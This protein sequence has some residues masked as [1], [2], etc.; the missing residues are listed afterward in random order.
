MNLEGQEQASMVGGRS[1]RW[2]PGRRAAVAVLLWPL[3]IALIGLG[4]LLSFIDQLPDPVATHWGPGDVPDGF[5]ARSSLPWFILL[6]LVTGWLLGGLILT[7]AWREAMHRRVTVGF[8][9]GMTTFVT[10]VMVGTSWVQRGLTDA[11]DTGGVEWPV[12]AALVG[13][14]AVG[15]LAGWTTPAAKDT[16]Q[17]AAGPV[18]PEASR[19]TVEDPPATWS[20]LAKPGTGMWVLLAV[21]TAVSVGLSLLTRMWI[22]SALLFVIL[23]GALLAFTMFRVTVR[24]EGLTVR[25]IIGVP[26]WRMPLDEIVEAKVTTVSPLGEFGGFGYRLGPGGR[27][28]F[29]VR[30]GEA[31]EVDRANGTAWVI[32]VDDAAEGAALLNTLADRTRR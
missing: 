21:V 16:P 13:A 26:T 12:V 9:A 25:S 24:E 28:G 1:G 27:T 20:R 10:V 22:F 2:G 32:T 8:A 14:I 29:V 5:S 3:A 17:K 18:P 4:V 6:G 11:R 30:N 23:V 15:V 7:L 31:L 19:A